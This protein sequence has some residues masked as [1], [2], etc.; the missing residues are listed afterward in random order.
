MKNI[1]ALFFICFLILSCSESDKTPKTEGEEEVESPE[2]EIAKP[3][4]RT[5]ETKGNI[6]QLMEFYLLFEQRPN[7][8]ELR[9]AYDSLV[10]IIPEL[11]QLNLFNHRKEDDFSE[12]HFT[13]SWSHNFF[14]PKEYKT[15]LAGYK[16]EQ[17][18][19]TDTVAVL[20]T[21]TKDFLAYNWEDI[22]KPSQGSIGYH[23]T[24]TD[25]HSFST[26]YFFKNN[27]PTVFLLRRDEEDATL[28]ESN[29]V[30]LMDLMN[31]LYSEA[32]YDLENPNL[33]L[34][35]Y[36]KLFS[37]KSE[38]SEPLSLWITRTARIA[39]LKYTD[40]YYD[41]PIYRVQAEPNY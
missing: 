33:L 8:H 34:K 13:S 41:Y 15:V 24:F 17:I 2:T 10:W 22:D 5:K 28:S 11:G 16:D 30:A 9:N 20:I 3:Q 36:N 12:I 27:R 35:Q 21:N 37:Y 7:L 29:R 40:E 26:Y 38:N 19:L 4:L 25:F 1:L 23:N 14:L 31:Q 39:L 32:R 18:I 6:F